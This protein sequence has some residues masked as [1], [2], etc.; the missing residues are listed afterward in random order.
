MCRLSVTVNGSLD[1]GDHPAVSTSSTDDG[2]VFTWVLQS[3]APS[4]VRSLG[5][6]Y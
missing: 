2:D 3:L 6:R 5:N 4:L 1:I